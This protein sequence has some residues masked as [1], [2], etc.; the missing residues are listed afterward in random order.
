VPNKTPYQILYSLLTGQSVDPGPMPYPGDLGT[1][2]QQC[3][4]VIQTLLSRYWRLNAGELRP[5]VNGK[6]LPELLCVIT[7]NGDEICRW[8]ID[9]IT[10]QL[11]AKHIQ[12]YNG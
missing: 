3:L 4:T 11:S 2:P 1:T 7:E 8:S 12:G 10:S 9:D 6:N 5:M